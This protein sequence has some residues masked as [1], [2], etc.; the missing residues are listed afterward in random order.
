VAA[1]PSLS[2][3]IP[4][5]GRPALLG[6]VLDRLD[7]QTATPA[8]FEVIVVADARDDAPGDLDSTL[9]GRAY[10]TQRLRGERIGASAARNVGWRAASAP[11]VL[12]LGDDTLPEPQL[13]AEHLDWHG[14]NPADEIGVLGHIR[15]A[16]EL[17]VTPFMRWLERGIQFDYGGIEGDE[18]DWT[19]FYTANASVKR[20]LLARVGGFEEEA[21]PFLYED[22]DLALRMREHGFRLLYNRAAAAEHLHA[23]D[24][25]S[26]E[27][28]A[29]QIAVSERAFVARHP[30]FRPYFYD[31]FSAAA[32]EPPARGWGARLARFVG[33][34][35]PLIGARV[36]GSAD[37]VYRQALARP[38]LDAWRDAGGQESESV[39]EGLS[40]S[41]SPPGGPK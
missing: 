4:T 16:D 23:V 24:I 26:W 36:W 28:R 17:R 32:A 13:V 33:P 29:A 5:M 20:R 10:P 41:G 15:W 22:L 18:A 8:S 11:V 30:T 34:S 7:G 21:L 40:S 12:F 39:A 31:L 3:V 2:V 6:R 1:D 35:F 38:F 19:H 37:A 9:A 25:E 14:S 27:R